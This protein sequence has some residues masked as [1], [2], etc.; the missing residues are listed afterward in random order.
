MA[1]ANLK[2]VPA[3]QDPYDNSG[4]PLVE[5][6]LVDSLYNVS[7]YADYLA[8]VAG[9][10]PHEASEN[11]KTMHGQYLVLHTLQEALETIYEIEDKK[12]GE[13]IVRGRTDHAES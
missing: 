12:G 8:Y 2:A 3:K 11:G 4:N 13:E 10:D 5:S 1:K 6:S 7:A 9:H